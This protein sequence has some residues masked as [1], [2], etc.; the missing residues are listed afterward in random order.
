MYIYIIHRCL[1]TLH[2]HTYTC[3]KDMHI[4]RKIY[5]NIHAGLPIQKEKQLFCLHF[6]KIEDQLPSTVHIVCIHYKY[7][8]TTLNY[9]Q[10]KQ[11]FCIHFSK[12]KYQSAIYIG[13][14]F[15]NISICSCF[16][17]AITLKCCQPDLTSTWNQL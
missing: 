5:Y 9:I 8:C 12:I 4:Q 7:T 15:E 3:R 10:E 1:Y 14:F 6:S 13:F 11:L 17:H 2:T 16:I